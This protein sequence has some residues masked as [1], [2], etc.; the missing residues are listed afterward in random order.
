MRKK[1]DW[2]LSVI[3]L[4]AYAVIWGVSWIAAYAELPE[5]V[6]RAISIT[7]LAVLCLMFCVVLYNALCW[8]DNWVLKIL[9]ILLT[10]FLIASAIAM[11]VPEVNAFFAKYFTQYKVPLMV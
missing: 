1:L 7:R 4:A 11:Q 2:T 8:T 3:I 6:A 9:F 10:A 5:W